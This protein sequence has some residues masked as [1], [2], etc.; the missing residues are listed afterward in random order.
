MNDNNLDAQQQQTRSGQSQATYKSIKSQN[1]EL[2]INTNTLIQQE[3][4]YPNVP[5]TRQSEKLLCSKCNVPVDSDISYEMGKG[6][7]VVII[8]LLALIITSFLAFLPC[9]LN[10]CKDVQHRCSKC[11]KLLGTKQFLFG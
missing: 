4:S 9:L 10:N 5:Q 11:T 1:I 8:I 7:Y 2:Q 3:S 6:S